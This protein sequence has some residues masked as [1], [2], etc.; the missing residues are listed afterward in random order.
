MA[1][2]DAPPELQS[3]TMMTASE[4]VE[5]AI[6]YGESVPAAPKIGVALTLADNKVRIETVNGSRNPSRVA[7][8]LVTV[9]QIAKAPD[10]EA[11]YLARLE[12]AMITPSASGQLGLYRIAFEGRFDLSCSYD[13]GVVRVTATR[14]LS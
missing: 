5:N 2:A 4:L 7:V 3:A 13:D 12:Q 14:A 8:L 11:L 9:D 10:R 1:L 6:K